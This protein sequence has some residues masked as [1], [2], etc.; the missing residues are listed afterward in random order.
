MQMQRDN[1]NEKTL[2]AIEILKI[3][4]CTSEKTEAAHLK[5][6]VSPQERQRQPSYAQDFPADQSRTCGLYMHT[7]AFHGKNCM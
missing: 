6:H 1:K 4:S 5:A 2:M 7:N 3:H